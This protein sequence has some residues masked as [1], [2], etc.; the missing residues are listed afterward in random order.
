MKIIPTDIVKNHHCASVIDDSSGEIIIKPFFFDNS[1][2]G[3]HDF[4]NIFKPFIRQKHIIGFESTGHY[5]DNLLDFL[6]S[7]M[8]CWTN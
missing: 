3:F 2:Y 5:G 7:F 4:M 1:I 8:L 6:L